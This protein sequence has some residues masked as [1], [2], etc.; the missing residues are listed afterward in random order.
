ME[1]HQFVNSVYNSNTFVVSDNGKAIIVDMGDYEPV[2]DFLLKNDLSPEA[3][4]ITHVHYDHIYGLPT[5]MKDFPETPVFTS[6]EGKES[7]KNPKWNF[8]KYHDDSISIESP[9]IK[10]LSKQQGTLTLN[11]PVEYIFTPG[12]D[13]SCVTY[14][15]GEGLF[16]GDSYIP[17]VKV[18]AT[19][20][21]SDKLKAKEWYD[22][23]GKMASSF[24]IYPGHGE[25]K[26]RFQTLN[27]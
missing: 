21:K 25:I 22:K 1:I 26:L 23:L 2:K 20:S 8:S 15:I 12:H 19:F 17:G 7:F 11:L 24:D 14:K 9:Q 13:H 5:F 3:V 27:N 16:T 18:V 10:V 6:E 4:L